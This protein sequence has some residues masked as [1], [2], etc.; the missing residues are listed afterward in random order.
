MKSDPAE[1]PWEQLIRENIAIQSPSPDI[2]SKTLSLSRSAL[3]KRRRSVFVIALRAASILVCLGLAAYLLVPSSKPVPSD[4]GGV[5]EQVA[6]VKPRVVTVWHKTGY[7]P[8]RNT[9]D[10]DHGVISELESKSDL[11]L[12][13]VALDVDT[14][15]AGDGM[16][17]S[18]RL[19]IEGVLKG[20]VPEKFD[21]ASADTTSTSET[22]SPMW[23]KGVRSILF[24]QRKDDGSYQVTHGRFGNIEMDYRNAFDEGALEET[25]R[26]RSLKPA[27]VARLIGKHGSQVLARLAPHFKGRGYLPVDEDH[28][29]VRTALVNST[30]LT[31]P[32]DLNIECTVSKGME[33]NYDY[34]RISELSN[35]SKYAIFASVVRVR[36]IGEKKYA[37]NLKIVEDLRG[38]LGRK[39]LALVNSDRRVNACMGTLTWKEGETCMLFLNRTDSGALDLVHGG[40]GKVNFP[41]RRYI[42][43]ELARILVVRNKLTAKDL[44]AFIKSHGRGGLATLKDQCR[45]W[46]DALELDHPDVR[47]AIDGLRDGR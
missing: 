46:K 43:E 3:K 36:K 22:K 31:E 1:D 9:A 11:I 44:L 42:S 24:S 45:F 41:Y 35:K 5:K 8:A 18:I 20:K 2:A 32:I 33:A 23:R 16:E 7:R 34:G 38:N 26:D 13:V 21:I 39:S 15:G 17:T 37:V 19:R 47:K 25:I 10:I 27:T 28:P 6:E 4:H 29:L 14:E 30:K 12:K 40:S